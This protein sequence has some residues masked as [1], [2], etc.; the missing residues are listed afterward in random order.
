MSSMKGAV[1]SLAFR[2]IPKG[3]NLF[4]TEM[5]LLKGGT[6]VER[7]AGEST[8]IGHAIGQAQELLGHWAL[9]EIE[10]PAEQFFNEVRVL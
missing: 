8:L 4:A 6:V 3:D 1:S 5:L 10:T 9:S 2:S 7:K